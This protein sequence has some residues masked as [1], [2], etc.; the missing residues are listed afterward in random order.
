MNNFYISVFAVSISYIILLI[1]NNKIFRNINYKLVLFSPF[2]QFVF[3][4]FVFWRRDSSIQI[5]AI[6]LGSLFGVLSYLLIKRSLKYIKEQS[7]NK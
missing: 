4:W 3:I 1:I 2:F 5:L 7:L 6:V